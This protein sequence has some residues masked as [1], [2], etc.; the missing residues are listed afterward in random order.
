MFALVSN[1][2][3][4]SLNQI[5]VKQLKNRYSDPSYYKRF[6]IGIDRAKMRLYDAEASAQDLADSGQD[7]DKP[8]NT[9]GNRERGNFNNKF[10]GIKV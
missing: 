4:D 6:V 9:F 1:E 2:E 8:V 5:L 10:Q 3:L 7:D